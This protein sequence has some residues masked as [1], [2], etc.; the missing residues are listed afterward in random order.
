MR[1]HITHA[2][3]DEGKTGS[4]KFVS[5]TP[6]GKTTT[7]DD[8]ETP[9]NVARPDVA[10]KLSDITAGEGP[11]SGRNINK[12]H[13]VRI[14]TESNVQGGIVH[15]E[16][17]DSTSESGSDG[18]NE[19]IFGS[20]G[21]GDV[22]E[23]GGVAHETTSG[24]DDVEMEYVTPGFQTVKGLSELTLGESVQSLGDSGDLETEVDKVTPGNFDENE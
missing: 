10:S 9:G 18:S 17:R 2:E 6:G 5:N 20:G 15:V 8:G 1:S 12:G 11:G 21:G 13:L 7:T 23:E 14:V 3:I 22:G 19:D 24:G 16:E 4:R